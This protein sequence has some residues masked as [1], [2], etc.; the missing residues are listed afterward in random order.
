M[1]IIRWGIGLVFA[2]VVVTWL[3]PGSV[4]AAGESYAL[5][6]DVIGQAE[7]VLKQPAANSPK[8]HS[9]QDSIQRDVYDITFL[10]QQAWKAAE[11]S[12]DAARKDYA[13]QALTLL[14]RAVTRDHF[15]PNK[16]EPV[17]TLIRQLLPNVSA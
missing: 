13:H 10:L 12:N 3:L 14:Q 9:Q 6:Y 5:D 8:W 2:G 16:I 11:K 4:Q 1:R 15:D 17:L 7:K